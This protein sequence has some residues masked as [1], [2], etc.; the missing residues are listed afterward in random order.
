MYPRADSRRPVNTT[1]DCQA[2]HVAAGEEPSEAA[3]VWR[4][5]AED[6]HAADA[7]GISCLHSVAKFGEEIGRQRDKCL[8]TRSE[9]RRFQ[10]LFANA[11]LELS[12][13]F[14]LRDKRGIRLTVPASH[15]DLLNWWASRGRA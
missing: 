6:R 14:G 10:V 3:V 2:L 11:R 12:E 8:I 5:T 1:A 9:Q 13:N 15:E 7:S 4:H